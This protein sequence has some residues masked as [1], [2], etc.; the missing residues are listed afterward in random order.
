LTCAFSKAGFSAASLKN[1]T[2]ALNATFTQNVNLAV[3]DVAQTV[4]VV[5]TATIIDTTTAQIRATFQRREA[6]DT[7][8]S[9]L[10]AGR[11]E[12]EP[13]GRGRRL[14]WR[15]WFGRRTVRGRTASSQQQFQYRSV[16][17]NRKG[18]Y[19]TSDRCFQ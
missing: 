11:A 13:L 7:P 10:P 3:G 1:L 12:P 16:D 6:I 2:V 4:E 17:N 8:S 19:G 18:R 9:S 5:E 14:K 15:P